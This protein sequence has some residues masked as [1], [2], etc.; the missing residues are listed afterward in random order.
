MVTNT[1]TA[2]ATETAAPT[3]ME[4]QAGQ[5][6]QPLDMEASVRL[7]E[8]KGKLLGFA[9]VTFNNA[10]T[11]TD[12][13]VLRNDD[14][15]LYVGMPSKADPG[16]RTGYSNT[17]R[18]LDADAKLQL[19]GTIVT[20]YYA[21]VEKLKARAAAITESERGDKPRI[22]DQVKA[23]AKEAEKH[24]AALPAQAK[25]GKAKDAER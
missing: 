9:N 16:S 20:E 11:V 2:A 25:E 18:I 4:Q 23:A 7:I 14:G 3:D 8:P 21:A 6:V 12:F 22:A 24:N 15:A 17:V 5:T 13:K 10:V 19:T 1:M